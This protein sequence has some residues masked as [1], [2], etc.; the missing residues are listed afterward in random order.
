VPAL[1][2]LMPGPIPTPHPLPEYLAEGQ[3]KLWYEE[4]KAAFQV[5]WMGVVTQAFSHYP[6]FYRVLWEGARD[7]L[8]SEVYVAACRDK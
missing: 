6:D 3:R 4:M 5:P 7:L 8:E 1:A 2:R